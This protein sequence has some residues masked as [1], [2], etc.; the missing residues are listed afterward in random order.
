MKI[1]DELLE[2][3]LRIPSIALT[4]ERAK[5]LVRELQDERKAIAAMSKLTTLY[6]M[7][8]ETFIEMNVG[9][10][11]AKR[12]LDRMQKTIHSSMTAEELEL[13]TKAYQYC[14]ELLKLKEKQK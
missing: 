13:T 1:T 5:E 7:S 6:A 10:D 9:T 4:D 8:L 11:A 2:E 3:M 12:V 14:D